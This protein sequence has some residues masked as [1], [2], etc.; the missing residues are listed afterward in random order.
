VPTLEQLGQRVCDN[1]DP[2]LGDRSAILAGALLWGILQQ[3]AARARLG[4]V[5]RD[6]SVTAFA[7]RGEVDDALDRQG[8]GPDRV[9]VRLAHPDAGLDGLLRAVDE[10]RKGS[11]RG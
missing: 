7:V 6:S 10:A 9:K 8:L 5:A 4:Y 11:R 2:D 3:Q 1:V